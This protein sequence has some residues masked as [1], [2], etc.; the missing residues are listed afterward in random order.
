M[1]QLTVASAYK[2]Y[3]DST[4]LLGMLKALGS[5]L[6]ISEE[7][8]VRDDH[9]RALLHDSVQL[10]ALNEALL[11]ALHAKEPFSLYSIEDMRQIVENGQ[12]GESFF[13]QLADHE[14]EFSVAVQNHT[15]WL[16]MRFV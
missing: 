6:L 13:Q 2:L 11:L 10:R 12:E 9:A 5:H 3:V 7:S 1:T 8:T 4:H 15:A 14:P 16:R